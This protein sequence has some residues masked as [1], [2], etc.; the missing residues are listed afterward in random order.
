MKLGNRPT[1][2][3]GDKLRNYIQQ[4][5]NFYIDQDG[6]LQLYHKGQFDES[7]CRIVIPSTITNQIMDNFHTT[8][9]AGHL[10]INRTTESIKRR[11]YWPDMTKHVKEFISCC[12]TCQKHKHKQYTLKAPLISITAQHPFEIV[13]IDVAGPLTTTKHG[14]R[15]IIVAMDHFS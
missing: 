15:Y 1:G 14:N 3:V 6:V 5:E 13:N 12:P 11:Y 8:P 7:K 4:F 9:T 10:G 2:T